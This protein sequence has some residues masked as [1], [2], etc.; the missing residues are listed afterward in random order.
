MLS[1][2][3]TF[4]QSIPAPRRNHCRRS[5]SPPRETHCGNDDAAAS[6]RR[7]EARP[8]LEAPTET[9]GYAPS[10]KSARRGPGLRR[11]PFDGGH[12]DQYAN[13][14]D[15]AVALGHR[16]RTDCDQ[17][18]GKF[19]EILRYTPGVVAGTFGADTRNDWFLIRGFK[20]DE[21]ACSSTACSSS[22]PPMRAGSCSR[23]TSSASKCCAAPRPC[24]MAAPAQAAS[25]MRSARCPR[26]ADP[27]SRDRRQ[28][29]RQRLSL[30]RFRRPGRDLA[31][32]RQTVLPR[33]RTSSERRDPGRF[34][35][36]QQL[37]HRAVADL[38]ARRRYN[39]HRAGVSLEEW[40]RG[41]NFLP[42]VGTVVKRRSADSDQPVR[43]RSQRRY[44]QAR[45]GNARL[46][47]RAQPLRRA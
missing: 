11:R 6:A 1:P 16:Q 32:E 46:P 25:S 22:T 47:V 40:T 29:F 10:S 35:A 3:V 19:D 20:S 18:P 26:R 7:R 33:G 24:C 41:L 13:H 34:H 21:S 30:V 45:T 39:L 23:S 44:V 12:Q 28:Q 42:Y 27:L 2:Q 43:Q 15:A 14:G 5:S 8:L 37:F 9:R 38:E 4:A 17:K 31:R 36:R